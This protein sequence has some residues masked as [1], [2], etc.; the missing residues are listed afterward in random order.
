MTPPPDD[1]IAARLQRCL[2]ALLPDYLRSQRWFG[3]KA[4]TIRSVSVAEAMPIYTGTPSAYVL[5]VP[6]EYAAAPTQVYA[7]PL[8]LAAREATTSPGEE[9]GPGLSLEPENHAP[10]YVLRDALHD[11]KFAGWLIEAI[12][13]G[14][15]VRGSAGEI[16]AMPEDALKALWTANETAEPSV[17]KGEQSNT[18]IRYGEQFILK[19]YRRIEEGVNLDQEIGRFLTG[20]ARFNHTP[21]LVGAVEYHA[22]NKP[23]STLAILQGYVRN[24]GDAWQYTLQALGQFVER[25]SGRAAVPAQHASSSKESLPPGARDLLGPYLS[26]VQLLGKRTAELHRALASDSHDPGFAPEDFSTEY[27][28]SLAEGMM[29]LAANTLQLL[30]ER[31]QSLPAASREKAKQLV[32]RQERVFAPFRDI[33]QLKTLGRRT[34]IH[35]DYHLGQVLVTA[36]DFAIIDFEGEPERPLAERRLKQSP[37]RDVA[38]M[39]RSFHYAA[40]SGD[41]QESLKSD[42]ACGPNGNAIGWLRMWKDWVSASFLQA[43]LHEAGEADFLPHD[44][45]D[46]ARLLKIL[47]VEKAMYELAYELKNRPDWVEI[48]LDGLLELL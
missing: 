3:G 31:L 11:R 2:P 48:P 13:D 41:R 18:S 34:R 15:T 7:L 39:L 42:S 17:M 33:R 19:F 25:V 30:R 10:P 16:V 36:D 8:V 37:L 21:P 35:G 45:E 29:D 22:A 5:L 23:R 44:M 9:S 46:V 12:R 28:Q 26:R 40:S 1:P 47:S 24:Q 20:K 6:V 43:Y 38:G 32:A 4:H 14:I 27:R